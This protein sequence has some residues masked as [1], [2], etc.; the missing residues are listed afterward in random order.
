MDGRGG[1][2]RAWEVECSGLRWV[3]MH[4]LLAQRVGFRESRG[5]LAHLLDP[6]LVC[7]GV[8]QRARAYAG[9]PDGEVRMSFKGSCAAERHGEAGIKTLLV[10]ITE[11]ILQAIAMS[12]AATPRQT[13]F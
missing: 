11:G 8:L 2:Q 10:R 6:H 4:R 1:R 13:P 9:G 5:S 12:P 3:L 7:H